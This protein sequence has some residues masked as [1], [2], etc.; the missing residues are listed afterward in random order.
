MSSPHPTSLQLT[1]PHI[2]LIHP[3]IYPTSLHL[4]P[5]HRASSQPIQTRHSWSILPLLLLL[6]LLER[7]TGPRTIIAVF[8]LYFYCI[9]AHFTMALNATTSDM[10]TQCCIWRNGQFE[11]TEEKIM[12]KMYFTKFGM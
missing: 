3:T 5:P 12:L 6:C 4:S 11:Q 9:D 1:S 8:L 10:R 7:L 2:I